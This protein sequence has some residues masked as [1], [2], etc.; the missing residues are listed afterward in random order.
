MKRLLST[1]IISILFV[2]PSFAEST[3][4]MLSACKSL[5]TNIKMSGDKATIS[6]T[7]DG[8]KCWGAFM[9]IQ[10]MLYFYEGDGT[11]PTLGVCVPKEVTRT[12]LISTFVKHAE[13]NPQLLH[14]NFIKTAFNCIID[15]FPCKKTNLKEQKKKPKK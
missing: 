15:A 5:T 9:A 11:T 10:N 6:N 2:T 12:Q 1:I 14:E 8:G 3:Q 13:D 7:F 4:E